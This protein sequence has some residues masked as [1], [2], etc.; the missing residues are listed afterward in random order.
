[1]NRHRTHPHHVKSHA[2]K[3]SHH[4]PLCSR[5]Y[6]LVDKI[7]HSTTKCRDGMGLNTFSMENVETGERHVP[8]VFSS[9]WVCSILYCSNLQL[10]KGIPTLAIDEDQVVLSPSPI[11]IHR[12]AASV[13]ES[14]S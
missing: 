2:S 9:G 10:L 12:P 1:M 4:D 5:F 13:A 7:D 8:T 3:P 6:V 11:S 14:S